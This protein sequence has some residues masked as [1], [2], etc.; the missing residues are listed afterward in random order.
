MS[1]KTEVFGENANKVLKAIVRSKSVLV[2]DLYLEVETKLSNDKVKEALGWLIDSRKVD[3]I[4]DKSDKSGKIKYALVD[5]T[6]EKNASV[7]W[8]SLSQNGSQN[9]TQLKKSTKLS[10][11][12]VHGALGWLARDNDIDFVQK[13][14]VRTF[15]AV[16]HMR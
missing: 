1:S 6:Y 7:I 3:A 10:E 4:K 16:T 5:G 2:G 13:G 12:D 8:R 11:E 14:S 15:S 9:I